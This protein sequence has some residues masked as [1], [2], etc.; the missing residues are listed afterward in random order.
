MPFVRMVPAQY[1]FYYIFA[2][3]ALL[4]LFQSGIITGTACM[5]AK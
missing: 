3:R 2:A 4:G 5:S 1:A